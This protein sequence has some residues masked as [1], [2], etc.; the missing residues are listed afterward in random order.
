MG[1]QAK[2]W[3]NVYAFQVGDLR[4]PGEGWRLGPRRNSGRRLK[5]RIDVDGLPTAHGS[6][7]TDSPAVDNPAVESAAVESAAVD[8][9]AVDSGALDSPSAES[10]AVDS[11]AH[12]MPPWPAA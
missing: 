12:Q 9:P 4:M 2:C 6:Q 1:F 5:A 11:L 3:A 8:S 7:A 10:S